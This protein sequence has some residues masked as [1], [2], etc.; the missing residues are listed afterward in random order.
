MVVA[1][2]FKS[3]SIFVVSLQSSLHQVCQSQEPGM[4]N[5]FSQYAFV[6]TTGEFKPEERSG[7]L[8]MHTPL[9]IIQNF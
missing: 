2:P 8:L 6:S 7:S 4:P 1:K 3:N 9:K 5:W